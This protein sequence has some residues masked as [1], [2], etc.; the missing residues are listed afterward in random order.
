MG[1]GNISAQVFK[2]SE[3]CVITNN[4]DP[5]ALI[6]EGGFGRVYK[7]TIQSTNQV[8]NILP[9]I[10]QTVSW[11]FLII[12]CLL[13]LLRLLLLRNLTEMDSKEIENF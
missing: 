9:N 13:V 3:L 8:P 6:G 4:F 11:H 1:K 12:F 5:A 2:Y 10:I 7:G